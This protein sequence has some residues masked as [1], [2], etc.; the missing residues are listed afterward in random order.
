MEQALAFA[1]KSG[2]PIWHQAVALREPEEEE[3]SLLEAGVHPEH[4]EVQPQTRLPDLL[5]QV[6]LGV[7]AELAFSTLWNVQRYDGIP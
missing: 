5:A 2:G 4:S 6:S 1:G 3:R 7:L